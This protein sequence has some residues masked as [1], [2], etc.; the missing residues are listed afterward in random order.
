MNDLAI[1]VNAEQTLEEIKRLQGCIND[2]FG[3]L[4]L[5]ALWNDRE[6]S[7]VMST[8]LDVLVG[9]LRL[10]FAYA[11]LSDT[12]EGPPIEMVRLAQ[13]RNSETQPRKVGRALEEWLT[14]DSPPN[15]PFL[16]PNPIGEGS[17]SIAPF[18]L[19]LQEGTGLLLAASRRAD[20]PTRIERMLLQ[21]AANQALIALHES[22][23]LRDQKQV[24][25]QLERQVAERTAEITAVNG[26]L[27]KEISERIC[28]EEELR[29]LKDELAGE[30]TAVTR[31]HQ[32]STRLMVNTESQP[33]LEEVLH[34]A[35][36]MQDGDFG[37]IQLYNRNIRALEIVAQQGFGQDLLDQF[38]TVDESSASICGHVL[39]QRQPVI[40]E[41]VQTDPDFAQLRPFA[42]SAGIRAAQSTPLFSH[43]GDILGMISIY[44]RRQHRPSERDLRMLDLY[45]RQAA[46]MVERKRAEEELRRSEA[47][48][49]EG[50]R[51]SHTGSWS[52][53]VFTGDLLWSREHFRI[54]GLDPENTKPSYE[55]VFR[56]VH[57]EDRPF[58]RR[59]F[60]TVVSEKGDFEA[61][62]RIIR[63]DGAIRHIHSIAHPALDELG[64]LTEYVGTVIDAT[65]EVEAKG[66]IE[67]AFEEINGLKE[68]LHHENVVL[69]EEI[70]RT[71]MFEEIVGSSPPIKSVL[72]R[73]AKV[74]PTESTVLITGETGTGKELIARAIHKRSNR[75]NRPF[76][77]FNCASVPT[78]L[79]ASELFGHEKGAFTGAQQR[80][81]GR[82]ELAE[83]GTLFLD[84]VGELPAEIQI[85]LLRV[86]QEREFDRVGGTHPVAANI[87]IITATNRDLEDAIVA[88]TFRLD[89]FYRL[90]VFPIE[91]PPLRERKDDI[92]ML[93]DY[94]IL[95]YAE[96]A[97]KRIRSVEKQTIELT[98]AYS[99]PG[100]IRELQNVVE[101]SVIL[102]EDENF[103]ID[104]TWLSA[105]PIQ[106]QRG[107][108]NLAEKLRKEE[109]KIIE[110]VL[111]EC[112]GRIAGRHGAAAKLGM[113]SSTLESKIRILKIK[114][115]HFRPD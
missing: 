23:A 46:E 27:R 45:A 111:A 90:N 84:E 104:P 85:A 18:R 42:Q 37:T 31:L 65:E 12:I 92:P 95:R 34:A 53:N 89:L 61:D 88:G 76:I 96:K 32:L 11:R 7:E 82:F 33:L 63:S 49:V 70:D 64:N 62:Y 81:L 103:S 58:F 60:E 114:K 93:L 72:S 20:F 35:L 14:G 48:L 5:P 9:M 83:G 79:I 29:A 67:R 36:V 39:R 8:L 10:D 109:K 52:W 2:L 41:D 112:K 26:T 13:R 86:L 78:S 108:T 51:I 44:F 102:C 22:Q 56:M 100:N 38:S 71:A 55:T 47:Q 30:L 69:R 80:R 19:G 98:K 105:M 43:S 66:V 113:P 16:A 59:T 97:G 40:V 6:S 3:V 17:I 1:E 101:R 50:Q 15:T 99:W 25:Q 4:A 75:K 57:P 28:A 115:N 106:P 91:M 110:V 77:A 54:F 87:R 94:F 68:R 73:I 24:T 21:V 107:T 74:A